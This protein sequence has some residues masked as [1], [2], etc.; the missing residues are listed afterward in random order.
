MRA[1]QSD[2]PGTLLM[3]T[4]GSAIWGALQDPTVAAQRERGLVVVNVGN[5]HI[6]A[7]LV[8]EDRIWGLFEHHTGPKSTAELGQYVSA[9][10]AGTLT[11]KEVYNDGGHGCAYQADYEPNSGHSFVAVT[12]P[13]WHA[14]DDLGYYRAAPHGDMMIAGCYGLVAAAQERWNG[15]S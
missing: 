12:G 13:N 14:A 3:D 15:E 5:G 11:S 10:Q 2:M 9:L 7:A 1:V 8:R 4:A 6:V